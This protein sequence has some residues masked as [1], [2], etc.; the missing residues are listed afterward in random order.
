LKVD[1]CYVYGYGMDYKGY[2]RNAPGIFA[3]DEG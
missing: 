3:I 1:D 2:L